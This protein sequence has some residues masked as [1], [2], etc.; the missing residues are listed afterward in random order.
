MKKGKKIGGFTQNPSKNIVSG[1]C[2]KGF[3]LPSIASAKSARGDNTK[4]TD[5]KR[6]K[7]T[8]TKRGKKGQEENDSG[9]YH[10]HWRKVRSQGRLQRKGTGEGDGD[11]ITKEDD[12]EA[13][14]IREKETTE[15]EPFS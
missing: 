8:C 14:R 9:V 2:L 10:S 3:S 6:G 7:V 12:L 1:W 13:F 5:R 11:T 4:K 15:Q